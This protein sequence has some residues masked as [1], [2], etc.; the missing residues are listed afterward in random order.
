MIQAYEDLLIDQC[1][2]HHLEKELAVEYILRNIW[3]TGATVDVT[4]RTPT[5]ALSTD[6][7]TIKEFTDT[8]VQF[9]A[10]LGGHNINIIRVA[11]I[12]AMKV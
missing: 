1:A 10:S 3:K 6:S 8:F 11:D 5:G 9:T 12:V 7:G 4:W 2:S